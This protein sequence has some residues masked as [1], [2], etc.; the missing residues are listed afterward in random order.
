MPTQVNVTEPTYLVPDDLRDAL[1]E[2]ARSLWLGRLSAD[3]ILASLASLSLRGLDEGQPRHSKLQHT[4][5]DREVVSS[6][7][8]V[9]D[10]PQPQ[11]SMRALPY[12]RPAVVHAEDPSPP[13]TPAPMPPAPP[14]K[15]P[16]KRRPRFQK[17]G[18]WSTP[19]PWTPPP[20][21]PRS[22][23]P[24]IPWPKKGRWYVEPVQGNTDGIY[25]MR[26]TTGPAPLGRNSR[27]YCETYEGVLSLWHD[28]Y[29]KSL[30]V[31]N[32]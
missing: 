24:R 1:R 3:P 30:A 6:T 20:G 14:A 4:P 32:E 8:G 13:S 7:P 10:A 19:T 22:W 31:Q 28:R 16:Y 5:I 17:P 18:A 15:L 12:N 23:R 11:I 29:E 27:S 2:K 26:V 25:H 21:A 9:A